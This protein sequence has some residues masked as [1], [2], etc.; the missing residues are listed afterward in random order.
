M[1]RAT[2][3]GWNSI[4]LISSLTRWNRSGNP[5]P[6]H[7]GNG[8]CLYQQ[9]PSFDV[10]CIQ[11]RLLPP[12]EF[13][14]VRRKSSK[15][16]FDLDDAIMYRSSSSPRP[17]SLSRWLKFRW[18]VKGSDAVTVGN[19]FLKNEVLKV[20]RQKKVFVIPTLHRYESLSTKKENL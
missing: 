19:Q 2:G 1:I 17:H 20:D 11:R 7:G 12:F 18:M 9:L 14:W 16:L 3:S 6:V 10:V 5:F 4:S 8:S 15:V 13:Y